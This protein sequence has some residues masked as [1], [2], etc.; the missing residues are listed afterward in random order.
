MKEKRKKDFRGARLLVTL[1]AVTMLLDL[2]VGACLKSGMKEKAGALARQP[3]AAVPFLFMREWNRYSE[4][5]PGASDGQEYGEKPVNGG[6]APDGRT[7]SV[8]PAEE[9]ET[10]PESTAASEPDRAAQPT[11]PCAQYG[12][13]E[14]YFDD[15][16][17]IGDSRM[18]GLADYARLGKADYFTQI[19]M[20]VFDLFSTEASDDGFAGTYLRTLLGSRQYGKIYLMLGLNEAGYPLDT[21]METYGEDVEELRRLQPEARIY[22]IQIYGVTRDKAEEV[23][24]LTPERLTA[25]NNGIEGLCD[26]ERVVLL[27][28]RPVYED[29]SGYLRQE[30]TGDGVHPYVKD[31]ELMARWL[32]QQAENA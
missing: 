6:T 11:E 29:G 12:V 21:L 4:S 7:E 14:E 20:T 22:L 16:L 8:L 15:A 9:Q 10:V 27:D 24:Y 13:C 17:F 5:L 31:M 19:G 1:L 26:G 28:P 3:A 30:L 32:C 18:E 23:S 25:I 2:G